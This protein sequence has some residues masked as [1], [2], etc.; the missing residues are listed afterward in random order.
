MEA[1][2]PGGLAA[3]PPKQAGRGA[4]AARFAAAGEFAPAILSLAGGR[5]GKGKRK[6]GKSGRGKR[7]RGEEIDKARAFAAY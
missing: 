1:A 2:A 3:A 6:E 4:E 5:K 7:G